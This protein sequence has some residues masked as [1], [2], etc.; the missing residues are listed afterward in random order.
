MKSASYI[1][2]HLDIDGKGKLLT[3]LYDKRDDFS[4]R[5]V[6]FPFLF[7]NILLAPADGVLASHSICYARDSRN[8]ADVLH[9][10]RLLILKLLKQ[11]NVTTRL[12]SPQQ[13]FN[14][15]HHELVDR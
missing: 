12:K 1:D 11:D 4:F 3:K 8:Y 15:R 7:G 6:I 13:K 2:Q 10:A 14:D 9:R 5:I